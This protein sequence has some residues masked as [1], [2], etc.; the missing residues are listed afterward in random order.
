MDFVSVS[1]DDEGHTDL[2]CNEGWQ[3]PMWQ[4]LDTDEKMSINVVNDKS[5]Q[6]LP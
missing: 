5:I 6:E 3:D 4:V 1:T 2:S